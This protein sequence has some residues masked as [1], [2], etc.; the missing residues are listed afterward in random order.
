MCVCVCVHR[1]YASVCVAVSHLNK[2]LQNGLNNTSTVSG[3]DDINYSLNSIG[4]P[5]G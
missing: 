5:L 1:V 2:A 4:W 3:C